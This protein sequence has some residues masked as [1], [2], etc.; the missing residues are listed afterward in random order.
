MLDA[1]LPTIAGQVL[2]LDA[3]DT[4][5]ILDAEGDNAG[6]GGAFSGSVQTWVD[7]S[8]SGFSV[9]AV[10]SANRPTY[11]TGGLNGNNILTFD[12]GSDFLQNAGASITGDDYTIFAVFN[13][14]TATGRDAVY[15]FGS[16]S[17]SRNGLYINDTG[18][19][20]V[21]LYHNTAF[22]S[23]SVTYTTSSYLLSAITLD[24][25]TYNLYQNGANVGSGTTASP[26]TTST[27]I[28]IGADATSASP[29]ELQGNIAEI[30]VY[31]RDLTAD[32]RHDVETYLAGK[33]GLTI[34]NAAP[35]VT[36][37]TGTTLNEGATTTITAG[38]LSSTDTDNTESTLVYT[39]TNVTDNGTLFRDADSDNIIDAGEDLTLNETFT[40]ADITAGYLRYTHNSS[41]TITD[42]FSFT[43]TDQ[44]AISATATF[45]FT[46]NPV[47]DIPVTSGA[48]LWL[49]ASD[50]STILDGDGTNALGVGG[51]GV[52]SG[53]VG[54]WD[55]KAGGADL[56][57]TTSDTNRPTWNASNTINGLNTVR[58]TDAVESLSGSDVFGGSTSETDVFIVYK[59]V[60][61]RNNVLF[62]LNGTSSTNRI[63]TH[64]PWAD[65]TIYWD[66]NGF[67][68]APRV[69]VTSAAAGHV[70][71]APELF[72]FRNS[73]TNSN[74]SIWLNG[75]QVASDATGHTAT[76]TGGIVLGNIA[77]F[78]GAPDAQIAEMII[79]NRQLNVTER[80]SMEAYL[81]AKWF[82]NTNPTISAVADQTINEDANTGALAFTVGDAQ[83]AAASLT[84]TATSSNT[85]LIPNGSITLGG[86][87]ANRTVTLTPTAN[88]SGA[89][90]IT[91][92]VTDGSGAQTTETFDV[93]VTAVNDAPTIATNTGATLVEGGDVVITTAMLN[94]GDVD[95]SG[96]GL[97]Y[98]ASSLT[99]G[100]ITVNGV[101]QTTFTQADVDAG[102][103]RFVH[104]GSE[105]LAASFAFSLADGGENGATPATG[106]FN[107][108]VTPVNDSPVIAINT[109]ATVNEGSSVVITTAM[110]NEGDVDDSGTGLTYTASSL[111]NGTITV[112]GV[113]QNTFT[114]ADIDAGI[115]RFVHD[116]SETL[117]ASFA[118]SLADGGENGASPAT[119][120]FNLTVNPL[121]DAPIIAVNTGATLAE[122]GTIVITT[123]ML[124]EGD[125]DDSGVGLTYTAS[126]LTNGII[127]VN[128]VTQNTF[129]QADVDAGLVRFIHNGGET[130][131]AGF[132]IS[133]ADGGEDGSTP[134]TGTVS[135]TI[136]PVNDAPVIDGWSLI[137][138]E[139]F[140]AG[141]TGWA[142]NTTTAGGTFFS[143]YLGPFSNDGGVQ[144]N[145]KTYTLTTGQDY[146]VIEF[147]FYRMDSWDNEEFR[148]W[149]N[150][151]QV[152]NQAFNT[153]IVTIPDGTSGI[154]SWTVSELINTSGNAGNAAG[155]NDQIFRFTMTIQNAGAANVKIGFG[156]T[157]NQATNDESWGIDNVKVYE[158]D[159]GG[160]PGP[161]TVAENTANGQV[162]GRITAGDIEGNA[163]T[164]SITGGT[165]ASAFAIN[166]ATGAITV[167]NSALL[168]YEVTPSFT[169][170]ITA[171]DNG[172]PNLTDVE[173]ITINLVDVPE[174]TAPVVTAAGP[175]SVAENAANATVITT[176]AATDAE[177][178]AVTWSITGGNTDNIF[179]ITAGGQLRVNSN[180][181]LNF[182]WDNQYVLTIAA[183]DNGFGALVGTRNV[184]IN[185]TD[186]NEAPTFDNSAA[187]LAANPYLRYNATTGNYYRYVSTTATY[188]AATTASSAATLFGVG[189]HIATITSSAENTY[190][191]GLAGTAQIWLGG[192]DTAVEGVW[193]WNVGG[194]E[195]GVQFWQGGG[196]GAGGTLQNGLYANWNGA[197]QP[198]NG[199][200]NEDNLVM[201]NT[202]FW[203][204]INGGNNAYVIEWEGTQINAAIAALQNGPYTVAENAASG[205]SVGFLE[206]FDID[207]G[208]TKTFSKTGGT[209]AALFDVNATTGQITVAVGANL[210]FEATNTYTLNVRVQ[211]TAGLFATRT[212]TINLSDV[213]ETPTLTAAGP[214][215]FNENIA[216]GTAVTTMSGADVDTGQTLTY[217]IQ[218]GNTGSM[219]AINS[220]T[221][222]ITFAGSPNFEAVSSYNLIVRVT[223]NGAGT[224]YAE[225]TVTININDLNET[226]TLA[227]AGPFSFNENIASGTSVV[228]MSGAD[229]DAGQ[230]LSYSIQSGN[231]GSMFAID[232]NTGA[233]TFNG[234]PD[235]EAL[236]SYS[237]VVRVTDNGAGTLYAER[238]VT[239]NI[240]DVN[241]S[242]TAL[243]ITA[244]GINENS[245]IGTVIGTLSSIDEDLPGD[246]FTYTI[247][248]DPDGKFA[249]VGNQL[250][251]NGALD[252]ETATSHNVTIRTNDGNGGTFDQV[253]TIT[254]NDINEAPTVL[255]NT[256]A[257]VEEGRS[258]VIRNTM[259]SGSDVDD[260]ASDITYTVSN[261]V[262]G[263]IEVNGV[264]QTSFTQAD[265]DNDLVRFVHDASQTLSASFDF[266]LADGGEDGALPVAG[267]FALSVG[268]DEDPT[269]SG[270]VFEVKENIADG[271]EIGRVT[272]ADLE[273][274]SNDLTLDILSGNEEGLFVLAADGV[275][276]LASGKSLNYE[277]ERTYTLVVRVTDTLGQ[278]AQANITINVLDVLENSGNDLRDQL[279]D[280]VLQGL[281]PVGSSQGNIAFDSGFDGSFSEIMRS[282]IN[283]DILAGSSDVIRSGLFGSLDFGKKDEILRRGIFGDITIRTGDI[284][285]DL[286]PQEGTGQIA[287][288]LEQAKAQIELENDDV[289]DFLNALDDPQAY[290]RDDE[291]D[292]E[293]LAGEQP[294]RAETLPEAMMRAAET[295]AR[296]VDAFIDRI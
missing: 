193:R 208:D 185:I 202:G 238:T 224:L 67:A 61:R 258:V 41:D 128:G 245:T 150:N 162:V 171:T 227:A 135:L 195:N 222:A 99:N 165:G 37:N 81:N 161:F 97:T 252:F 33:W 262:N 225:R 105:T 143:R 184:T 106:T 55:N 19:G 124:N 285:L 148:I 28:Y 132:S 42:A 167:S 289:V 192:S 108:S 102:I 130:V 116:G 43:V 44:K 111:T 163:I 65:N 14:T 243:N 242:P 182:E 250:R 178:N 196:S 25:S 190:V 176:M 209:G 6:S 248:N 142:I 80:Q 139:N 76:T 237:L 82:S 48:L 295:F 169:L 63:S 39:V 218:S 23:P 177:G 103:V 32:E 259:L 145:S 11:T 179:S 268:P 186:I 294:L 172:S 204:D 296:E 57:Q 207:A 140:E 45:N 70:L 35:T 201:L 279:P 89:S 16:G 77:S 15:E 147:D 267:T 257:N 187:L 31:D 12:G 64:V 235:F 71:G 234:S 206:A 50:A 246:S 287:D 136:T 188:A 47:L 282:G 263:H 158:A 197:T 239:I 214:F 236:N 109:G 125:P 278:T 153:G 144:S 8:T 241:E 40:Q 189:G 215:A 129:T 261:L 4:S 107:L 284:N 233:I 272:F 288:I 281:S 91:I 247:Q 217:S 3:D 66:V 72:L 134:A 174:N 68:G 94:E 159:D 168:N 85:T 26:R 154:A 29:D 119:G 264:V 110:L 95:D 141:A 260:A 74:Q 138:S 220:S 75:T 244:T 49:D 251:V 101:T 200:G 275:I 126:G 20:R 212:V 88:L 254:L 276:T 60:S 10:G 249:I 122:G 98:T 18:S 232:A 283:G 69:S 269:I 86:S 155:F 230:T 181:N 104:D 2:W 211:D 7:K 93:N 219:F 53:F 221:G 228:T 191:R 203:N 83:T 198:D 131:I 183:T 96:T 210:N 1:S 121:N 9:S 5:T 293:D 30:I 157:T 38:M 156:S 127:T 255:L 62:N 180:T 149:I 123:A 199:G 79:F 114:Q 90:T 277:A 253:F 151:T 84:V 100:T 173:T 120:T 117:A 146:T 166:S 58:F 87:G 54:T 36:T 137:A 51:N 133:L 291:G 27:G 273:D 270:S 113:T 170:Q 56:T 52:F 152:F 226:P 92:T 265:I 112:G 78:G 271:S 24:S 59:E 256:G 115:V 280:P 118:F 213:N 175:F 290:E 266:S 160:T 17:G 286:N 194:T 73:V 164:Y 240:N 205:S 223:D 292:E 34:T 274:L 229:V 46:I 22:I 21:Q 216:G 231:T 13:R